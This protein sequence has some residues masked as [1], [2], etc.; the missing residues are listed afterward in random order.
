[1]NTKKIIM[2]RIFYYI[3]LVFGYLISASFVHDIFTFFFVGVSNMLH[4]FYII[5]PLLIMSSLPI[6]LFFTQTLRNKLVSPRVLYRQRMTDYFVYTL[7]SGVSF[8]MMLIICFTRF[9]GTFIT[10]QFTALYPLD[11]L[12]FSLVIFSFS[13]ISLFKFIRNKN[14]LELFFNNT[15]IINVDIRTKKEKMVDRLR[16]FGVVLYLVLSMQLYSTALDAILFFD[17]YTIENY[18]PQII[19]IL[20][21]TLP[22][23][24]VALY[25]FGYMRLKDASKKKIFYKHHL[26]FIGILLTLLITGYILSVLLNPYFLP[27]S[28]SNSLIIDF[29]CGLKISPILMLLLTIVPYV[30]ALI[31]YL[32]KNH[33]KKN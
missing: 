19:M 20:F 11:V 2:K 29:M 15:E 30:F 12:I 26:I 32:V 14:H 16:I 4:D 28:M 21:M 31:K 24:F 23:A 17:I 7:C 22:T 18:I 13:I 25:Y 9:N 5:I 10:N 8:F 6:Y 1:M 27:Q 33:G 3:I